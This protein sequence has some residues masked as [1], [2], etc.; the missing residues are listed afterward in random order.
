MPGAGLAQDRLH[1]LDHRR[2]GRRVRLVHRLRHSLLG[3]AQPRL[4]LGPGV[5]QD[6]GSLDEIPRGGLRGGGRH[7]RG[8]RVR[9]RRNADL[10]QQPPDRGAPL[11]QL[12]A[13]HDHVPRFLEAHLD[14]VRDLRKPRRL[15]QRILVQRR[16]GLRLGVRE[17][18]ACIGELRLGDGERG[19]GIRQPLI[20]TRRQR[21]R[22]RIGGEPRGGALAVGQ[23]LPRAVD[24]RQAAAG[25]PR[26]LM[27]RLGRCTAPALLG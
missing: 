27:L 20:Q 7:Q 3:G 1:R 6:G 17:A 5:M 26:R 4:G 13:Q 21:R 18:A 12:Q 15:V 14:G 2:V 9:L 8:D 19:A 24:A 10:L 22:I 23:R 11:L 16:R 25:L